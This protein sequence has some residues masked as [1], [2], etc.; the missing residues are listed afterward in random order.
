MSEN[1]DNVIQFKPKRRNIA[2][3]VLFVILI[4][5]ISI[6]FTGFHITSIEVTGNK[7]Y[8]KEQIKDFVL[9][10]GYVDNTVLLMLRNKLKKT[11]NIPCIAKL[12][13]EYV[14]AHEIMVTVYEK[15]MAGCISYMEEYVYFDQ[16]G[17]VLEISPR[18]LEDAPCISGMSF[19]SM[20]L[21]E[22]L[23]IEDEKRFKLILKMRTNI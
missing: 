15:V 12:D 14:N 8:S 1:K 11:D 21:H 19:S 16:D 23:P 9:S 3:V 6:L 18:K 4:L 20:E 2:L 7:Y 17:Y 13:I 22:K 10:D 5:L